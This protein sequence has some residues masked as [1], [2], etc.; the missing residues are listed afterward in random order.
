MMAFD[1]DGFSICMYNQ[2]PN[3]LDL[4]VLD[5]GFFASIQMLQFNHPCN[6]IDKLV[7]RVMECFHSYP[8]NKL[9]TVFLTLQTTM[10][11]ILEVNGDNDCKIVHMNK[12]R[13]EK[14]GQLPQSIYALA[15][16]QDWMNNNDDMNEEDN[17][18][19]NDG[20]N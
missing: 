19:E 5:L 6:S 8:H 9:N 14:L 10:N 15:R 4:N 2:P 12:A 13:L 20:K 18:N 3:S 1:N 16:A 11:S 7:P 17:N